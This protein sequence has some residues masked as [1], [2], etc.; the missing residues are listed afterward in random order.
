MAS[1][2]LIVFPLPL[3]LKTPRCLRLADVAWLLAAILYVSAVYDTS[4]VTWIAMLPA[5]PSGPVTMVIPSPSRSV[6]RVPAPVPG[7]SYKVMAG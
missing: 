3:P 6:R 5:I 4:A 7:F 2:T 1:L